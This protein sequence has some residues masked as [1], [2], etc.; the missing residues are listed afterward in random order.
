MPTL[1]AGDA[2][3]ECL[4]SLETQTYRDFDVIV[5]DNSADH[6]VATNSD[7]IQ[8][9]VNERNVG[10][11]AAINQGYRASTA[12]YIAA[13]NDDAVA[14]PD[15]LACLIKSAESNPSAGM[16]ASEVRLAESGNLDSAGMLIAADGSS[17]QR[18]HLE[19]PEQYRKTD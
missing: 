3:A 14:D 15:W 17:R 1:A 5:V 12:P 2:L 13:L 10:F 16:F 9:I 4:R 19:P 11:G 18:G 8:V 7:G 6:L